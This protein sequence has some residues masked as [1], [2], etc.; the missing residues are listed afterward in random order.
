MSHIKPQNSMHIPG[1]G[2]EGGVDDYRQVNFV[3]A[4]IGLDREVE[5]R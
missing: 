1:T 4:I 3:D 5:K 2:Y